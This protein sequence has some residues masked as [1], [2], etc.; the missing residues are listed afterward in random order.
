MRDFAAAN[1]ML[2]Q[3]LTAVLADFVAALDTRPEDV[4]AATAM[5]YP[6]FDQAT[7][8]LLF[9]SESLGWRARPLTAQDMA[10]DISIAKLIGVPMPGIDT[11]DPATMIYR[12]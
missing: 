11:I 7:L 3:T 4:K 9:A 12:P 5:V 2:M 6:G 1:P 8:D 10:Q